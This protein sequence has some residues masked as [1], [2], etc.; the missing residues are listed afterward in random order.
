[1]FFIFYYI[2]S[3]NK[4]LFFVS[5]VF[6]SFG[7]T[8]ASTQ[9]FQTYTNGAIQYIKTKP[10]IDYTPLVLPTVSPWYVSSWNIL[11]NLWVMYY[12]W[13]VDIKA[14]VSDP[15]W[16]NWTTCM[17]T[18]DTH[19]YPASYTP[20]SSTSWYCYKNSIVWWSNLQIRFSVRNTSN[21][22]FTWAAENYILDTTAPTYSRNNPIS[23]TRYTSW[24]IVPIS[25]NIT[26]T[27]V[28]VPQWAWCNVKIDGA[29]S[30]FVQSTVIYNIITNTCAWSLK[31]K[32]TLA[33][34]P[35]YLTV[36][37]SDLLSNT[38][39]SPTQTINFDAI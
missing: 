29:T 23:W 15:I 33:P 11:P 16:I 8:F 26:D 24:S 4:F 37:V 30:S 27:W 12:N 14:D 9:T 31:L 39:L 19:R 28:W 5:I 38:A 3:M 13:I 18:T 35:H 21:A 25:V 10:R 6:I 22:L 34:W 20:L 7:Y 36:Q 32:N 1:M 2:V 17:Y